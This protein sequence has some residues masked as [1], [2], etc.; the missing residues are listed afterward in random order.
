MKTAIECIGENV[1]RLR[2]ER[3][4]TQEACAK[5]AGLSQGYL[6]TVELGKKWIGPKSISA[7][8]KALGVTESEL[9]QDCD[10]L[11][12]PD[13]KYVL[14]MVARALG[15]NLSEEMVTSLKISKPFS[16]YAD[17]FQSMPD[18]LCAELTLLSREPN[19]DWDSFRRKAIGRSRR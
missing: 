15:V 8:A 6:Q 16:A 13:P 3:G 17:L 12:E 5:K 10:N 11:P 4:L 19:W 1:K 7:L 18:S 14:S 9:F 2:R